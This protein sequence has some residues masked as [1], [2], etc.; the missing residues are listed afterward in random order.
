MEI[1]AMLEIAEELEHIVDSG[2][3]DKLSEYL[4]GRTM[5]TTLC[6]RFIPDL[7]RDGLTAHVVFFH[8]SYAISV[9]TSEKLLFEYGDEQELRKA[10]FISPELADFFFEYA[11]S[12][13]LRLTQ[14]NN[15]P[16]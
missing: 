9:E 11:K 14:P 4:A 16:D 2:Q 7:R 6:L 8:E 15:L 1:K 12:R 3:G 10:V 13:I 5:F